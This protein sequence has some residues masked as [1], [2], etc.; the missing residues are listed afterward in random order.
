MSVG[1][2]IL[3]AFSDEILCVYISTI[4]IMKKFIGYNSAIIFTIFDDP[5]TTYTRFLHNSGRKSSG[6]RVTD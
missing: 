6:L 4:K 3:Y 5:T 2:V 1:E